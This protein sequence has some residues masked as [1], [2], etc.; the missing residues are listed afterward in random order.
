MPSDGVHV[1]SSGKKVFILAIDHTAQGLN[2]AQAAMDELT[3][4]QA[5]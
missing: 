4:N 2:V 1:D 5:V 3:N